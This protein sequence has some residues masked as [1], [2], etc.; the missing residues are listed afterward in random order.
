MIQI[1]DHVDHLQIQGHIARGGMGDVYRAF[2]LVQYREVALKIADGGLAGNPAFEERFRR[3]VQLTGLLD[4]PVLQRELGSGRYRGMPYLVTAF[5]RGVSLRERLSG[6]G[7]ISAGET[8]SLVRKIAE[9][10]S[11]CHERGIIHRDVKPDNV[12]LL[13]L[14]RN[15]GKVLTHKYIL[16]K[17]WGAESKGKTV[18]LRVYIGHLRKKL[19][20]D[21][22]G[23]THI[24]TVSGIGY[25]WVMDPVAARSL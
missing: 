25:G 3:E 15:A 9:G 2:D 24:M 6:E 17:I 19:G 8:V 23:S 21:S 11:Y 5:V 18:Y 4:H 12:L 10:L 13:L 14:V 7:P 16:E 1:G 20:E 22:P